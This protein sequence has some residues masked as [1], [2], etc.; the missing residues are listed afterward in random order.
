MARE[1]NEWQKLI[2]PA[3][4]GAVAVVA[5]ALIALLARSGTGAS[6]SSGSRPTEHPSAAVSPSAP[7]ISGTP[8]QTAGALSGQSQS[9][10]APS[11]AP[12]FHLLNPVGQSGWTIVWHG[13]LNIGL[14]GV[15]FSRVSSPE[16]GNGSQ[17]DLQYQGAGGWNLGGNMYYWTIP[18]AP[19]PASCEAVNYAS[20]SITVSGTAN[21]GD[22]YCF[23]PSSGGMDLYMQVTAVNGSSV[24]LNA[25]E[26]RENSF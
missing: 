12:K 20:G 16:Q 25:W 7:S 8:S 5:A 18:S 22:K 2:L 4:I 24:T 1:P 6:V 11:I 17:F 26:W 10:A 21:L 3:A 13:V 15:V 14:P 9:A 19:G 23:L